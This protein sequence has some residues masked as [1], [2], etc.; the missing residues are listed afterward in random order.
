MEKLAGRLTNIV[1]LGFFCVLF[2]IPII[3]AG[4]SFTALNSAMKSH[5]Y[6]DNGKPLKLFLS[7]FKEKFGLSTKVWALHLLAIAVLVWDFVYY[8]VGESTLD[9]LASAGIFVLICFLA[10]EVLMVFVVISQGMNEK[11]FG[12]IKTALDLSFTCVKESLMILV[13][14]STVILASIFLF[15]GLIPFVPGIISYLSWQIIPQMLKK[16]KFKIR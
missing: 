6:D 13:I 2:S 7:V 16:Y 11:V 4:A 10:F 14:T 3:T 5:L 8:R 12:V 15:R 9:T 1:L